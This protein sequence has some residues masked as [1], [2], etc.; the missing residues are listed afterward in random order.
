MSADRCP[1]RGRTLAAL[2]LV[3]ISPLLALYGLWLAGGRLADLAYQWRT[4]RPVQR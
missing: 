1:R 3:L 2:G 4:R